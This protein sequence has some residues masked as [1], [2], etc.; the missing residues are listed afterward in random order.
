MGFADATLVHLAQRESLLTVFTVDHDDFEI[1]RIGGR[2]RFRILPSRWRQN[3]IPTF[4]LHR[5]S[6]HLPGRHAASGYVYDGSSP[7]H[8]TT[9]WLLRVDATDDVW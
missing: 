7:P 4:R 9:S 8:P 1:Y 5:S 3:T 2:R 6:Q